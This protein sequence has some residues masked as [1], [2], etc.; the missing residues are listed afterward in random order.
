MTPPREKRMFLG[1]V[2]DSGSSGK[3]DTSVSAPY[4]LIGGPVLDG[5]DYTGYEYVLNSHVEQL[6]PES[7]WENFEFHACE[8]FTASGVFAEIG[9]TKCHE[10][11]QNALE[12]VRDCKFPIIY[13]AVNRD[14]LD[15]E[16]Y[17]TADPIDIAFRLYLKSLESWFKSQGV[18][19]NGLLI[20]DNSRSHVRKSITE[21][22][23]R[24][25][26]RGVG[27]SNE[28]SFPHALNNY[29][30]DDIYFGDS[31]NSMGIQL[32]DIC[33]CFI[34]GHLR[35]KAEAEGFYKI[36]EKS[37]YEHTMFP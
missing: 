27:K 14:S 31:K 25:R 37:I 17:R 10:L 15:Q 13:G 34:S 33:V 29:L 4:Q 11:M 24:H 35:G 36:I 16:L 2:D 22:F 21:V 5:D 20:V 26:R 28:G 7:Q 1:Y 12:L 30:L 6:V 3:A 19:K 8:M 9:V 18:P 23:Y 32:A